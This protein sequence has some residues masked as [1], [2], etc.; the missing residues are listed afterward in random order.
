MATKT[1]Q[2]IRPPYKPKELNMTTTII[3]RYKA[4]IIAMLTDEYV[5]FGYWLYI[6]KLK[7]LLGFNKQICE[8][9]QIL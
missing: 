6:P 8:T 9:M 4:D 7:V 3:G 2:M 1:S 5:E